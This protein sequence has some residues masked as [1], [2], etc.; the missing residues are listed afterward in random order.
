MVE[1]R[2]EIAVSKSVSNDLR[3]AD[4]VEKRPSSTLTSNGDV[5]ISNRFHLEH[6]QRKL[7]TGVRVDR[8]GVN[9]LIYFGTHFTPPCNV[10]KLFVDSLEHDEYLRGIPG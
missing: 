8:M 5:A 1:S 7:M 9:R 2:D 4:E 3:N 10:I 6:L